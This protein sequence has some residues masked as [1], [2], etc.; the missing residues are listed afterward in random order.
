[1]DRLLCSFSLEEKHDRVCSIDLLVDDGLLH[2]Q[3]CV[4]L[5]ITHIFY[6]RWKKVLTKVDELEK[7]GCFHAFI[8]KENPSRTW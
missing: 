7:D 5:A 2:T 3:V 1:M 4:A 6:H 8:D